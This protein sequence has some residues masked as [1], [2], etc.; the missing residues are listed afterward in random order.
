[1]KPIKVILI[2]IIILS[3]HQSYGQIQQLPPAAHRFCVSVGGGVTT[4]FADLPNP[5]NEGAA[6]VNLDY[7]I[8]EFI[9]FGVE[10]QYGYL[11]ASGLF[12]APENPN[13]GHISVTNTFNAANLNVRVGIGQF[14]QKAQS[15]VMRVVK[16]IY[17][18]AGFG[19]INSNV[20][21]DV[22]RYPE[23]DKELIGFKPVTTEM[24]V[25]V[26]VGLNVN[27]SAN[28]VLNLNIQYSSSLDDYLDGYK[29]DLPSNKSKDS[30][31]F[32]S[33][34]IRYDFGRIR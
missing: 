6:R 21:A 22:Q 31:S 12:V 7:N 34:G 17:V 9:S 5:T 16:G 20:T 19:V 33:A 15:P 14:M 28:L 32:I 3:F 23:P 18:G 2:I 29:P 1:M 25:P 30:Y 26:N 11:A 13:R 10:G 24:I 27:V 4:L 8:T